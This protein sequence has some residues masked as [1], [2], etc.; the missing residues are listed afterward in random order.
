[1]YNR[2]VPCVPFEIHAGT[3]SNNELCTHI[4]GPACDAASGNQE[5]GPGEG[6]VH[7]HR[8][9]HSIGDLAAA[10]YTWLNPAAEVFI[11]TPVQL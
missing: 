1:M 4:P 8:G 2:C 10:T 9:V 11:A 6:Y 3:E 7:S 5:A